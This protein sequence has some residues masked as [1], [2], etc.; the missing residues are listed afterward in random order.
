MLKCKKLD[1]EKHEDFKLY[2]YFNN[3]TSLICGINLK[4][5]NFFLTGRDNGYF[6]YCF[7]SRISCITE[8]PYDYMEYIKTRYNIKFDY[9]T[10]LAYIYQEY[11]ID[12]DVISDD[13]VED[14]VLCNTI[15]FNLS[16]YLININNEYIL[17]IKNSI[18]LLIEVENMLNDTKNN[19]F[20][21]NSV[22]H[23]LTDDFSFVGIGLG[24]SL[25]IFGIFDNIDIAKECDR[26]IT[27]NYTG[28]T[29]SE[30]AD[31]YK[32][33]PYRHIDCRSSTNKPLE[34]FII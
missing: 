23:N 30:L 28:K 21:G 13:Y 8:T 2:L 19:I 10:I 14:I 18:I 12:V 29:I 20:T 11:F 26:F 3:Y 6:P 9:Q 31:F 32:I 5:F 17:K 34:D 33:M 24:Y 27:D 15:C 1:L 16:N 4:I 22:M 25:H 7:L